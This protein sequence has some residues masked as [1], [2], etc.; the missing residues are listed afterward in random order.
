MIFAVAGRVYVR[1]FLI[2]V[3]KVALLQGGN[4]D[5]GRDQPK[6]LFQSLPPKSGSICV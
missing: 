2:K 6:L 5:L 3:R 4:E 1:S